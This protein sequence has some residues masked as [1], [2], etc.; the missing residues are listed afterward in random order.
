MRRVSLFF[1]WLGG[2]GRV[3]VALKDRFVSWVSSAASPPRVRVPARTRRSAL[4]TGSH[5]SGGHEE[6]SNAAAVRA[7]PQEQSGVGNGQDLLPAFGEAEAAVRGLAA[8]LS[9]SPSPG[10]AEERRGPRGRR[11]RSGLRGNGRRLAWAGPAAG[12]PAL[13][14]AL[15]PQDGGARG[16]GEV[17]E[18]G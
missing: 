5:F 9:K 10:R 4:G 18:A 1:F 7:L 8:S 12:A 6:T 16:T 14:L 3:S 15:S 11:A 17:L 2:E 13:P